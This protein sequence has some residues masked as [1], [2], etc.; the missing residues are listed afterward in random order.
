MTTEDTGDDDYDG[1]VQAPVWV[2]RAKPR[3]LWHPGCQHRFRP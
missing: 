2:P 3:L 1:I